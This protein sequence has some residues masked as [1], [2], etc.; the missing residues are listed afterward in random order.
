MPPKRSAAGDLVIVESPARA[1]TTE[2][3]T[4]SGDRVAAVGGR[5]QRSARGA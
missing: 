5:V 2:P 4:A 3:F 1:T